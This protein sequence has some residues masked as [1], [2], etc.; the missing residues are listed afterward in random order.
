MV[1]RPANKTLK[2]TSSVPEHSMSEIGATFGRSNTSS[3][4]GVFR[5]NTR[6]TASSFEVLCKQVQTSGVYYP[7]ILKSMRLAF[8]LAWSRVSLSFEDPEAARRILAKQ[9]LH[10]ADRGQRKVGGLATAA[11][12]DLLALTGACGHRRS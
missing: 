11:A 3:F 9:I 10:H 2:T 5:K 6:N 12:D 4:C 8:D 1:C 7:E